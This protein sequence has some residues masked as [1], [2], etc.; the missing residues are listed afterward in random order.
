MQNEDNR[1]PAARAVHAAGVPEALAHPLRLLCASVAG[2]RTVGERVADSDASPSVV[3]QPHA[4][5][6]A[7]GRVAT[8]RDARNIRYR[9][10]EGPARAQRNVVHARYGAPAR[11][12]R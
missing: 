6:R 5:P 7:E 3:S 12:R 9:L 11:R 8:R 4:R 10:A 1:C 2:E